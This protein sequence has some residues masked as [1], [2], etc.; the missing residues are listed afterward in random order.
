MQVNEKLEKAITAV[1][2]LA[3]VF[4]W[5]FGKGYIISAEGSKLCVITAAGYE[6]EYA[7]GL[8]LPMGLLFGGIIGICTWSFKS[9]I[10]NG[11]KKALKTMKE[12]IEK[13]CPSVAEQEEFVSDFLD[14]GDGSIF[15]I[16]PEKIEYIQAA[17][18]IISVKVNNVRTR[19]EK[20]LVEC[21]YKDNPNRPFYVFYFRSEENRNNL[22][23][24]IQKRTNNRIAVTAKEDLL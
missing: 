1:L 22:V 21:F 11:W 17:K 7:L 19:T 15:F 16:N 5:L 2:L 3:A 8:H 18:E 12:E 13:S 10:K 24:L 14:A 9:M 20:Y 6:P 4:L 23:Q